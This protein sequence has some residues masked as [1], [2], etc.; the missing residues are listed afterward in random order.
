MMKVSACLA[1]IKISII[2]IECRA[3]QLVRKI[4]DVG[5]KNLRHGYTVIYLFRLSF[6]CE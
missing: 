4:T 3:M 1:K 2:S 5:M 6:L